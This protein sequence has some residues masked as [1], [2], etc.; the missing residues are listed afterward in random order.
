MPRKRWPR[1]ASDAVCRSPVCLAL[2]PKPFRTARMS[3]ME[4]K[5]LEDFVSLANTGNFSRSAEERNVTQP[6]FSRRIKALELWLGAPLVDRSTYRSEGHTS[7]LQ[8][9]MRISY[10]VF[11]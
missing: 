10:A 5:W 8:S 4:L 6:A 3:S 1:P 9:L 7:E 11:C 2:W